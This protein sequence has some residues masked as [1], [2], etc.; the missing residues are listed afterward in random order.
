MK[1]IERIIA[2]HPFFADMDPNYIPVLATGAKEDEFDTNELLFRE[3]EPANQFYLILSGRVALET[4]EPMNGTF[5]VE[6]IGAEDVVGWSWLFP[7]FVWHLQARAMETTSAVILDG[8]HLL[9]QA[10]HDHQFGYELMKRIVQLA[11]RRLRAIRNRL[12]E[13]VKTA[14]ADTAKSP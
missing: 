5:P 3:G 6:E 1:D 13:H 10:E 14:E 4:H 7:P 8:G 9:I 12:L 2:N 11:V